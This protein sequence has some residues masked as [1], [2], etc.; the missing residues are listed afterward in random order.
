MQAITKKLIMVGVTICVVFGGG[1]SIFVWKAAHIISPYIVKPLKYSLA[2]VGS[3]VGF[4]IQSDTRTLSIVS[5][6][7]VLVVADPGVSFKYEELWLVERPRKNGDTSL[8]E[9]KFLLPEHATA[10]HINPISSRIPPKIQ[11]LADDGSW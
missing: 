6:N 10:E 1:I 2:P 11:Q 7:D 9:F 4:S 5:S 3:V 8:L